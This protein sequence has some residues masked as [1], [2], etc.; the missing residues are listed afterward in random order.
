MGRLSNPPDPV[1]TLTGQA[2]AGSGDGRGTA[3]GSPK[4]SHGQSDSGG[5]NNAGRLSNPR[6]GAIQ[7]RL[8]DADV[9]RLVARYQAG[10]S[11]P[12]LAEDLGVHRRTIAAH[13]DLRGVQRRLNVRKMSQLDVGDA[14]RRYRAG[15]SLAAIAQVYKVHAATVRRELLRAGVRIRPRPGF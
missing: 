5:P 13:L 15:D 3:A 4:R 7:R 11:L 1:E 2:I 12:A 8:T 6:G 14:A 9:D 10:R